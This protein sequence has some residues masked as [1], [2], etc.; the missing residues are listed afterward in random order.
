MSVVRCLIGG[1]HTLDGGNQGRQVIRCTRDHVRVGVVAQRDRQWVRG[2]GQGVNDAGQ[3]RVG[4][5]THGHHVG[6]VPGVRGARTTRHAGGG[7]TDQA[8]KREHRRSPGLV[9]GDPGAR[10][11]HAEH[12]LRVTLESGG[13][14][15]HDV[16]ARARQVDESTQLGGDDTRNGQGGLV[17]TGNLA[18]HGHLTIGSGQSE[19]ENRHGLRGQRAAH[20]GEHLVRGLDDAR[21]D[22][23]DL[24]VVGNLVERSAPR[25]RLTSEGQRVGGLIQ[26]GHKRHVH[27]FN[28]GQYFSNDTGH[29]GP[30][31]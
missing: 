21:D 28:R 19:G 27:S 3:Q 1:G 2:R 7:R 5:A 9:P 26:R 31:S 16:Q 17:R 14:V 11:L 18:G 8:S 25:G 4:H 6:R 29:R 22:R 10:D 20:G 15:A 12:T 30:L 24:R 13:L 23:R